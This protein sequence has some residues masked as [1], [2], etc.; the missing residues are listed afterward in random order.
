MRTFKA[1]Y[2]FIPGVL[3]LCAAITPTAKADVIYTYSGNDFNSFFGTALTA[4]NFVS[5]SFTF[6]SALPGNLNFADERGSLL[7]WTVTDQSN[8][9]SQGGGN[10]LANL[11]LSTNASGAIT[12][13]LSSNWAFFAET[14]AGGPPNWLQIASQD[15]GIVT[16]L[17]EFWLTGS[18]AAWIATISNDPGTWTVTTAATPEPSLTSL[19]GGAILLIAIVRRRQS[20]QSTISSPN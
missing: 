9:L 13:N 14:T 6:A 1:V 11:N 20:R 7:N 18:D 19:L 10:Y 2:A 15:T 3:L 16:D 17:S 5:A 12:N 4:S 8:T